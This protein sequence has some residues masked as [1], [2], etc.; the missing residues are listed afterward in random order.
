MSATLFRVSNPENVT[1][2]RNAT[3]LAEWLPK[4]QEYEWDSFVSQHPLGSVY[5]TSSWKDVP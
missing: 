4:D 1:E 5:H 2:E 3:Y